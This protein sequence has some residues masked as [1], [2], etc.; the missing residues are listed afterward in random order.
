MKTIEELLR[1][2]RFLQDLLEPDLVLIAG[3]GKN[4]VI[5]AGKFIAREGEQA[6]YAYLIRN[7]KL[8]IETQSPGRKPM[9]LETPG[10]GEVV[11]WSWLF[12]PYKWMYDVRAVEETRMLVMNGRCL[13]TKAEADP[14]LGYRLMQSFARV[15][16]E[17]LHTARLQLIDLYGTHE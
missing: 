12:P 5:K 17:Q 15:M 2:H 7:G 10:I 13:R 3:C 14:A 9:V 6:D 8:S 1:E 4:E 11:G 16:I